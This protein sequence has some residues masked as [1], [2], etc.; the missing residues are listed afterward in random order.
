VSDQVRSSF[1]EPQPTF[2]AGALGVAGRNLGDHLL[3][4]PRCRRLLDGVP[5]CRWLAEHQKIVEQ[6]DGRV[7]VDGCASMQRFF[8]AGL[9]S[10][11]EVIAHPFRGVGVEAAHAGHLTARPGSPECHLQRSTSCGCA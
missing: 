1:L 9:Q 3:L 2:L 5:W 6:R 7:R 8:P 10:V 11:L 4:V